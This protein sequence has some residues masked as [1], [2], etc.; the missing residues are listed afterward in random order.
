MFPDTNNEMMM[1]GGLLKDK[2]SGLQANFK[3]TQRGGALLQNPSVK[4]K[5]YAAIKDQFKEL[6]L[7]DRQSKMNARD[8]SSI[9][10]QALD[11]IQMLSKSQGNSQSQSPIRNAEQF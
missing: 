4:Q 9:G 8:F 2:L 11:T 3:I 7:R 5:S 10:K 1:T 6:R